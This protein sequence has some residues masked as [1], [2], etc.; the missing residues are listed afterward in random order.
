[1]AVMRLVE[2][3]LAILLPL[4]VHSHSRLPLLLVLFLPPLL[5]LS[6]LVAPL[7]LLP[8]VGGEIRSRP[9]R[10]RAAPAGTTHAQRPQETV[11]RSS[12]TI[13]SRGQTVVDSRHPAQ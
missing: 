11:A 10:C 12:P 1:M 6:L 13:P 5:A 9:L 2:L 7:P 8:V 3:P 4:L